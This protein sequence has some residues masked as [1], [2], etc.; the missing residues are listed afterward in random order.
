V[1]CPLTSIMH[2]QVLSLKSKAVN[3]AFLNINSTAC[4][5]TFDDGDDDTDSDDS[6]DDEQDITPKLICTNMDKV[7]AGEVELLYCHPESL[8]THEMSR[9]LRSKVY[10]ERVCC[11]AVDEVHMISEW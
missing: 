11:I 2:D 5:S 1:V 10:Q 7:R 4:Q 9:I 8:F 3:A 6:D